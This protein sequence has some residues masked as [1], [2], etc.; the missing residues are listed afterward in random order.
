MIDLVIEMVLTGA[1]NLGYVFQA[2]KV[3]HDLKRLGNWGIMGI[4]QARSSLF[5]PSTFSVRPCS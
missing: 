4:L 1:K 5:V 2:S 3:E